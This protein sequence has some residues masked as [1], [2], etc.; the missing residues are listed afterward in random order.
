[1]KRLISLILGM[2]VLLV[3]TSFAEMQREDE[4][5]TSTIKFRSRTYIFGGASDGTWAIGLL[6]NDIH[7]PRNDKV[8]KVI[9]R[10]TYSDGS[11]T[12]DSFSNPAGIKG[13]CVAMTANT[14]ESSFSDFILGLIDPP[15]VV[16]S[17]RLKFHD[18][19]DVIFSLKKPAW[20][21]E[22]RKVVDEVYG[23]E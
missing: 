11:Y 16:I 19:K 14:K 21:Q 3:S 22:W 9:W 4:T 1:M 17:F 15:A 7:V 6:D 2:I 13:R 12:R 23:E 20:V 8:T 5:V 18:R 10:I